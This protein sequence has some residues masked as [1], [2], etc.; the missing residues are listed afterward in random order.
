M[1]ISVFSIFEM[2]FFIE[3]EDEFKLIFL[4]VEFKLCVELIMKT[5]HFL[6][7]IQ[8]EEFQLGQFVLKF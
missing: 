3:I 8:I 2:F 7:L 4:E 6:N 1:K 5:V